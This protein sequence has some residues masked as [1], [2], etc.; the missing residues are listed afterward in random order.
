MNDQ[1]PFASAAARPHHQENMT[2][3]EYSHLHYS[4][5]LKFAFSSR[6]SVLDFKSLTLMIYFEALRFQY[7]MRFNLLSYGR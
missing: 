6:F 5:K 7:E 3:L 1:A 4:L 2:D